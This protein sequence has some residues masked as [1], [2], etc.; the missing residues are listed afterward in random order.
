[1]S[2]QLLRTSVCSAL[3]C[4]LLRTVASSFLPASTMR[5]IKTNRPECVE[6]LSPSPMEA[7]I[8]TFASNKFSF[9]GA[10][11]QTGALICVKLNARGTLL[12]EWLVLQVQ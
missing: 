5:P 3:G 4:M 2:T 12:D 1:M 10:C 7:G 11:W 6:M 9:C 8:H